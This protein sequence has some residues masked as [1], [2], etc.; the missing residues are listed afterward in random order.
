MTSPKSSNPRAIA[1]NILKKVFFQ[2]AFSNILLNEVATDQTNS[3]Q[4]KNLVFVLVHGVVCWKIYLEYVVN[5][6]V[7]PHKTPLEI[8]IILWM[9]VYQLHFL[10]QIPPYAIVNEAV[11]L[12]KNVNPKFG[13]LVNKVLKRFLDPEQNLYLVEESDLEKKFCLEHAF[14]WP[15]Y[16]LIKDGYGQEQAQIVVADSVNKPEINLR[17]NTLKTDLPSFL[18]TYQDQFGLK[19]V[20]GIDNCFSSTKPIIKTDLYAKGLITIQDKASVLVGQTLNP[21][22]KTRVLDM[23][24]APGGKLTHL[25]ALMQN[26]GEIIAYELNPNRIS[27]IEANLSRLGVENV[28]LLNQNALQAIDDAPYDFILLDAPCSGFGV[29]KRKPE[30]KLNFLNNKEGLPTL[31]QTQAALLETAY[32]VLKPLGVMVYST[33]TI[34]QA[35]NQ[36]QIDQFLV[37]HPEM[38]MVESK[39]LFGNEQNSDGFFICKL[40][41]KGNM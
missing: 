17:V 3:L 10:D 39:Q 33:C 14:P 29:L 19:A 32:H 11:N 18:A 25:A 21:S 36:A 41:K 27:L 7:S 37:N 2:H 5:K 26:T 20:Q 6:L 34:N 8:Q 9:G 1:F 31:I 22:S 40:V 4:A 15:L 30:I 38:R 23:C 35:E 16:L 28:K 24:S 13:G 12:A